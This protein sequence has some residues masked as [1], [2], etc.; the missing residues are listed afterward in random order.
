MKRTIATLC[1]L[2]AALTGFCQDKNFDLS[3]YKF[4][5]YKRHELELNFN[6]HGYSEKRNDILYYD[7]ASGNSPSSERS[8]SSSYTNFNLGYQYD[9][10][11]RAR[12]DYLSTHF[13]GNYDYAKTNNYGDISRQYSPN[14]NLNLSGYRR[15]YQNEDKFFYEGSTDM[16]YSFDESKTTNTNTSIAA[17]KNSQNDFTISIGAGI[18]TGRQEKVSDLWQA[19]YILEKLKGQKS[20]N[21][22]LTDNDIYEFASFASKLKNK[23]FFDSR[24]QKIAELQALDSLLNKQGLIKNTDMAYFTTLNDFWSYGS[25]PDRKSGNVLKFNISPEYSERQNKYNGVSPE[26][27]HKTSI[28]STISYNSSKQLNLFWERDFNIILSNETLLKKS[29]KYYDCY[30]DNTFNSNIN[31]GYSYFPNSRT[32]F[33]GH[34]GYSGYNE[35]VLGSPET[36]PSNWINSLYF[37]LSAYYYLSPR[38][39]ISGNFNLNYKDKMLYNTTNLLSTNYN[40]GL[41]YAIF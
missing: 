27:S 1:L 31:L 17:T 2:G 32:S 37:N 20:L 12:I 28:I 25:F 29:G 4:P 33:S 8:Y 40:L 24:L 18:G 16:S 38:L 30:H 5:D 10:L 11:S 35:I 22:E 19:Y 21:R 23:R 13:S 26:T 9:F 3:K 39:Q 34:F 7:N 14:I 15:Y 36:H 6:S 41:R